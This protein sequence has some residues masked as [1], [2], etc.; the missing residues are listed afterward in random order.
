MARL[1]DEGD[2]RPSALPQ[3]AEEAFA[4][5]TRLAGVGAVRGMAGGVLRSLARALPSIGTGIR[6]ATAEDGEEGRLRLAEARYRALI[7]QIPAVTFLASLAGGANDIYVSPQIESLLGFTQEEW[8][9]DPILWYRQIHPE[10][11]ERL[12]FEFATACMSGQPFRGI[13]RVYTRTGVLVWVH[14]EARFVHDETGRLLFLQ[15][16]GFDITEQQRAQQTRQ[17]LDQERT[18]RATAD[19][20]RE[21]LREMFSSLPAVV[22]V[23]RGPEHIVEFVNPAAHELTGV[24]DEVIGLPFRQAF[25][26]LAREASGILDPVFANGEPFVARAWTIMSRRWAGERYFNL[27]CQPLREGVGVVSGLLLHAVEVTAEVLIRREVEAALQ[28]KEEFLSVASHELRNPL[29]SL[30][31]G[32]KVLELLAQ[33]KKAPLTPEAIVDRIAKANAQIDRLM[34]LVER[35]LDVSRITAGRLQLE[36]ERVDLV[37]VVREAVDR[38]ASEAGPGQIVISA[39]ASVVGDWDELRLEQITTN[40]VT[41]AIKYGEGRAIEVAVLQDQGVARLSVRDHGIGLTPSDQQ[42]VFEKFERA[43][44]LRRYGGLGLGLWITRQL[45]EAMSGRIRVESAPGR[46]STFTVELPVDREA[47][48]AHGMDGILVVDDESDARE[49]LSYYL[50]AKG[51]RVTSAAN[52]REALEQLKAGL[53]PAAILLDLTMPVMDGW[54]F[55]ARQLSDPDLQ[56]IPVI[57]TSAMAPAPEGPMAGVDILLKPIDLDRLMSAIRQHIN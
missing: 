55:R 28:L 7:E 40:L 23:L 51:Y 27:V 35:L 41:N 38:S 31:L 24:G 6:E 39:P 48:K 18:A 44:S 5:L 49:T 22:T 3:G 37:K 54:E 52:G 11:R 14:A 10:D 30:K 57:V 13:L 26:D 34:R 4:T 42:R 32:F 50:G 56:A 12:S 36:L 9:S 15:G 29:N 16:V 20:D 1:E 19:R 43:A 17:Q 21:R 33:D 2:G 46:G 8:I 47:W 45:V 53:R 25:P